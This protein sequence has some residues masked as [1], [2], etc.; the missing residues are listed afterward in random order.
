MLNYQ[1]ILL[2][3]DLSEHTDIIADHAKI[4]AEK[5]RAKISILYVVEHT[6]IVYGSGEFSIPLDINLEETLIANARQA[7]A[8][9]GSRLGIAPD[10]QH[11]ATGSI[12]EAVTQ[13]AK[14]IGIDL[15]VV[16]THRRHGV[17]RLLGATANAILHVS[18]CD[19]LTVRTHE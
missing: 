11:V 16:G 14:K 15:I 6:P 13:L 4:I 1:H 9:L 10:N 19:V 3:T 2:T 12:K 7:L 8:H 17:E 18:P 5:C